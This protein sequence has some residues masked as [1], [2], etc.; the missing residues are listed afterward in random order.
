MSS[1]KRSQ[2]KYVKQTIKVT[3]WP[4]YEQALVNR[5]S[6]TFWFTDEAISKWAAPASGKAGGQ[7]K[8]SNLAIETALAFRMVFH[9]PWRQTKG[10]L[11]SLVELHGL[12]LEIP[13]TRRF[14]DVPRD[15]AK[16]LFTSPAMT[17]RFTFSWTVPASKF[18]A[19]TCASHPRTVPGASSTLSSMP[20][21]GM[22]SPV[23][24]AA[25]KLAMRLVFPG[26]SSRSRSRWHR[27][28]QT[29]PTTPRASTM[30]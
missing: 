11:Q 13:P 17:D 23:I 9:L 27:P 24:W 1:F 7:R 15:S 19:G 10:C 26:F 30:R 14:L 5:G 6:L 2:A 4:A 18:I 12:T 8:Y 3:N 20:I 28:R 21:L 16:S 25:T 29:R 22:S